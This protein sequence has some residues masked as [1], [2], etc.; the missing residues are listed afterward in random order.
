MQRLPLKKRGS[1]LHSRE[2]VTRNG[3]VPREGGPAPPSRAACASRL[4]ATSP[5]WRPSRCVWRLRVPCT[6]GAGAPLCREPFAG[7]TLGG[8][9]D[10][11]RRR[12]ALPAPG[13]ASKASP[14][15]PH[16]PSLWP[17][18]PPDGG[19][20]PKSLLTCQAPNP[21]QPLPATLPSLR[22]PALVGR[23]GGPSEEEPG[24]QR[25]QEDGGP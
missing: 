23:G 21:S 22:P 4:L 2:I 19:I 25:D 15:P 17:G 16:P 11:A 5:A 18:P 3:V 6:R 14:G 9:S 8:Q 13:T 10:K 7:S 20:S 1:I 12:V 24:L